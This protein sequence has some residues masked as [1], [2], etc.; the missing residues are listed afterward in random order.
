M[1]ITGRACAVGSR[2][3]L[4]HQGD[5]DD[6]VHR[7][8]DVAVESPEEQ[9]GR[10]STELLRALRDDGDGR[11]DHVR[12]RDVVEADQRDLTLE[13]GPAQRAQSP[14]REKVLARE[15]CG[16]RIAEAEQLVDS[17]GSRLRVANVRSHERGVGI[18]AGA[19]ERLP[20]AAQALARRRDREQVSQEA[21]APVADREQ[22]LDRGFGAARVVG[23]NAVGVEVRSGAVDEDERGAG[24]T[25]LV[26]KRVV[27][28]CR[29]DD[30]AVDPTLAERADELAFALGIVAAPREHK[31]P[32]RGPSST[33]GGVPTKGSNV[34]EHR[35][36]V[37]VF[38]RAAASR[39][40]RHA[41]VQ[42]LVAG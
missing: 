3:I 29:D 4:A 10:G 7:R 41:V 1:T 6:V 40:W 28:A 21:D 36:M 39:H 8:A 17:G 37:L 19:L 25:L 32:V 35:P 24:S 18:D 38:R 12:E 15:D 30:D 23:D 34:L 20:V 11:V 13:P 16:G 27:T 31:T 5:G 14:D 2:R 26:E 33:R 22:V 42:L 9:L